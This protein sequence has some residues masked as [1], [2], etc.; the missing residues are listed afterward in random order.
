[1]GLY[2]SYKSMQDKFGSKDWLKTRLLPFLALGLSAFIP[3][4]HATV[5]FPYDQLQ[6]QAGLNYYYIEGAFMVAGVV[7]LAVRPPLHVTLSR[8]ANPAQTKFP[9]CW[10][11][12]RFDFLGSSHQIFH[13]FVVFGTISHFI[14]ILSGY[15]WNYNN[16]RCGIRHAAATV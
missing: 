16:P 6:K 5:L 3:I 13:C 12:G 11:P 7:F 15:D 2:N 1:M 9:E 8:D 10:L 14:G 4:L